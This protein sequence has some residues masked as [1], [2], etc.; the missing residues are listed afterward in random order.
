MLR[1]TRTRKCL[2]RRSG[3]V[4]VAV[5]VK[6]ND[7]VNDH[8]RAAARCSDAQCVV[9]EWSSIARRSSSGST[10]FAVHLVKPAA[11]VRE[12]SDSWP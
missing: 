9:V 8:V 10:G 6:V 7:H 1:F 2:K 5:A 12:R 3:H 4:A 11:L